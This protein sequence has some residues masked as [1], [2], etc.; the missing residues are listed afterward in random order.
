MLSDEW[1]SVYGHGVHFA[2]TFVDPTL[3]RGTCYGAANWVLM[4]RTTGRGKADHTGRP[5]RTLKEVL[6]LPLIPDFQ[7]RLV[8]A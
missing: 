2:E 3:H 6:G 8:A 1:Q 5:N 7:A 4:G